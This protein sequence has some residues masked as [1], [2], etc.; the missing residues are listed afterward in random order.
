MLVRQNFA[1]SG[2]KTIKNINTRMKILQSRSTKQTSF[3]YFEPPFTSRIF[4]SRNF[5]LMSLLLLKNTSVQS[6]AS[7]SIPQ[8]LFPSQNRRLA[9]ALKGGG[10]R[11]SI[12]GHSPRPS[13]P[14]SNEAPEPNSGT[15]RARQ[16][17][18]ARVC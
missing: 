5:P 3:I 13:P 12:E 7:P 6:K 8:T 18:T 1:T 11:P 9:P 4:P 17:E 16:R 10:H 15:R 2:S 14:S